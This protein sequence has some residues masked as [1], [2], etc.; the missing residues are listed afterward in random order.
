MWSLSISVLSTSKRK[1][2]VA[3][4]MRSVGRGVPAAD[5]GGETIRLRWAPRSGLVRM[6][7]RR[8]TEGRLDD[9]PRRL[10]AVL[11]GEEDRIARHGIAEEALVRIHLVALGVVDDLQLRRLGD[12]VLARVPHA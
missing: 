5:V 7:G 2:A 6:D 11:A 8:V 12:R 3:V 4:G 9:R 10:H 1:V